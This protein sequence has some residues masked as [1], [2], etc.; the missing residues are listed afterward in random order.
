MA[1][2]D[3]FTFTLSPFAYLA[4][5]GL[6]QVAKKHGATI[7]YKPMALMSVFEQTGGTPPAQRHESR[8]N[9]RMQEL[10]RVSKKLD[11]KMNFQP[12]HWPTNPAPSCYAIIAA[13]E[14][15][16]GDVGGL[17]QSLL[18]ACWAEEKDISQDDVVRACLSANG[19]D[20][21]LADSGMLTGA[22]IFESNTEEAVQRGVF[23]AP[24]YLVDDQVFWGQ[25]RLSYLDDY[26]A[27]K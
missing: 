11:M 18:R 26:L 27:G 25:D 20:E 5:D 23:G 4:G 8:K 6:E 19:F 24:T 15:G 12:A 10:M 14:A 22:T 3:Y 1:H 16:G 17:V 7:T 9:Y 13:Q 2:I 21:G